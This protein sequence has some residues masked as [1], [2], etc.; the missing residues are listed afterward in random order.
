MILGR[1]CSAR[2]FVW[3]V[4]IWFNRSIFIWFNCSFFFCCHWEAWLNWLVVRNGH[5]VRV[6]G[7]LYGSFFAA[8]HG[9]A[10]CS[11]SG[12]FLVSGV[13]WPWTPISLVSG[14]PS[15]DP[16][17]GVFLV[18]GVSWPWTPI[19]LV[20][21]LPSFNFDSVV[22]LVSGVFWPWTPI[23]LVSGLPGGFWPWTSNSLVSGL[24]SP[25]SGVWW[26]LA[27]DSR[28]FGVWFTFLLT[29]AEVPQILD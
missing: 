16:D 23:S 9:S 4:L 11:D 27:L 28:F 24:P 10:D 18:S 19:C 1:R 15:F 14:L 29:P 21:G 20:S 13:S 2:W 5:R 7:H 12:V 25:V 22:F 17:S 3:T 8:T 6:H 26:T